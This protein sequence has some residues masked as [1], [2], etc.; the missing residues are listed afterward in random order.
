MSVYRTE[1]EQL[2]LIK[3]WWKRYGNWV[4]VFFS[5]VLLCVAGYRVMQNHHKQLTQQASVTY[6]KMMLAVSSHNIPSQLSYAGELIKNYKTSVYADVAHRIL[7]KI[8]IAQYKWSEAKE[9]LEAVISLSKMSDLKQIARIDIARILAENKSYAPAIQ[10]LSKVEDETYFS[11][12][13]E[14]KGDI[15][16]A[17]GKYQEAIKAYRLATEEMKK[18]NMTNLF[19]EMK[20]NEL[21]MKPQSYQQFSANYDFLRRS[22]SSGLTEGSSTVSRNLLSLD[23]GMYSP[24]IAAILLS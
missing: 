8:Y 7:A 13:N 3:K 5:L 24:R 11:V 17:M 16:A 9:E 18:K 19:L 2:E 22:R 10:E 23:S 12:I 1:E 4:T 21:V 6:E 20:I 15:Y 14:L